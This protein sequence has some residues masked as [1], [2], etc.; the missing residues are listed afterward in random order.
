MGLSLVV[1]PAHAGKVALLLERYLDALERDPWLVV[2]NRSDIER[3]ELDLLRRRPALLAGRIGTFDDLFEQLAFARP[4]ARPVASEAQRALAVR[5]AIALTPLDGLSRSAGSRGFADALGAAVGEV[6]AALLDADE[7]GGDLGRL[8]ASYRT[9]LD[10]LGMWDRD[11][12]RRRAVERLSEDLD[13][14]H[15]E[16]VFAYGFEDLTGAEWALLEALAGRADVTVSIPYEPGRVAFA[17]LERTVTD[18][19]RLAD[20]AV[21]ELP[22]RPG[23]TPPSPLEHLERSLFA[24]D[25]VPSSPLDG[26]LRF[27]EGAGARGTAELLAADVLQLVRSGTP[28]EQVGIVCDSVER[29]RAVLAATF[30]AFGVPYVVEAPARLGETALGGALLSLLRFAWLGGG[31][32]ELYG[33]LRSPFSGIER[34]AVDFAEGRLRGRAIAD[35]ERVEE[36]TERLRGAP[37]PALV[38]LR[39]APDPVAG[40][41]AVLR[42]AVRHAW[43]LESPPTN[44]DARGDARA[45]RAAERVLGELE[46]FAALDGR[47]VAAEDVVV[48]LEQSSVRPI[49]PGESGRVAVLDYGRARTRLF[50]VVFLLGLEEGSL[51]RRERPSPFLDDDTR[52]ELGG[53]LERPSPV[54]YS[55]YLFYTACTRATVRLVLVREA[56]T[57]DGAPREPSP[58]WDDVRVLFDPDDV[59][60]ATRRRSLSSS[61]WPLESAPSDRERLRAVARLSVGESEEARALAAANG[62]S[63]RLVRARSAF[64]R[65]TELRAPAVLDWL[66]ARTVFA[67]TELER[68]ADCSSAWLVDRVIDPKKIDAEPDALLRGQVVHATL[69]RFYSVLPKELGADRVTRENLGAALELVRRCLDESLESGVRLDLT[70]LQ[71]AELRQT[72]LTDLEGFVGDEAA[73]GVAFVPRRFEV[74]FGSERAAPELQRGLPLADGLWLSGKIDRIDI[75]PFSARGIV[76][77]YKSGAGAHSAR[78]IDRELRLQI[79]LYVLALGDLVGVEPL[80]GVYRALSGKRVTRGMLRESAKDDLPGFSRDDYLGEDEFW[81]QVES[82]RARAGANAQRIRAGDVQ[83][84]PRWDGACPSWCDLWPVCR[85]KRA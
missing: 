80:G 28:A 51:P 14:W 40:A 21:E 82:A 57:D 52:R 5:R 16:P 65:P 71:A 23:A 38:E 18:L 26:S 33:Y 77:D 36:E 6:D 12:V 50:D 75:D 45:F 67:A 4:D 2:P 19:A 58:F 70:D 29:W 60:R 35:P 46:E 62:W 69:S 39:A 17:A 31:R 54:D 42:S 10:R 81:A 61:T 32:S 53:R 15:G 72:L 55:R 76:Q 64:D 47:P 34:R 49:A 85:V 59:A 73:S 24:D 1:G 63:R 37:V 20:G 22:R 3:V 68:F 74:A 84:D 9:E 79:P 13:A 78:D 7:L 43:G 30:G 66:S 41:R 11:R 56:A 83:H 27:L 25:S 48:A 44:D 8:V